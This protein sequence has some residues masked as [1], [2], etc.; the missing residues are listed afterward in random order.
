[1]PV[2]V[3]YVHAKGKGHAKQAKSKEDK[4]MTNIFEATYEAMEEAKKAYAQATTDEG[5]EAAEK[6]YGE[7]K[8]RIAEQGDIAWTIWRAY[9]HSRENENSI[10]NF[11]DIIWD[12]DVE[13]I[14]ACLKENGITEFT[15]SCRATDAVETLWLFK[16][17]GC[18]IGE[19]VEVNLRKDI[20]GKT[21]EKGHAFKMSI[22]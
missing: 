16:E 7:A 22:A 5:Q 3:I 12:R 13:A 21:Y 17:A 6:A 4:A 11:D 1:M 14:T 18:T 8:D 20:W 15:Y 10:L 9:E 2:R 19:M